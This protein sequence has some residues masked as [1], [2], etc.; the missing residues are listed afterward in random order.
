MPRHV[1]GSHSMMRI[2]AAKMLR[3]AQHRA[4]DKSAAKPQGFPLKMY[5]K[6][7]VFIAEPNLVS[8]SLRPMADS[9]VSAAIWWSSLIINFCCKTSETLNGFQTMRVFLHSYILN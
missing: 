9:S 1:I 2:V 8:V 5:G 7:C 3:Q 4:L 6:H